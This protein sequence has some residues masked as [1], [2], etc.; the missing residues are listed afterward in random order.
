M[1]CD[2]SQDCSLAVSVQTGGGHPPCS[3][4]LIEDEWVLVNASCASHALSV[5]IG[6]AE[7]CTEQ[8]PVVI[9][10]H[11]TN[12]EFGAAALHIQRAVKH[13]P[14]GTGIV[15]DRDLVLEGCETPTLA[16]ATECHLK[17]GELACTMGGNS[18]AS[19]SAARC[20]EDPENGLGISSCPPAPPPPPMLPA[21]PP[22]P[23]SIR[24]DG[25][26]F[27]GDFRKFIEGDFNGV[28]GFTL[29]DAIFVAQAV[30]RGRS[31]LILT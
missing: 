17:D 15:Y 31:L 27:C 9:G 4:V 20:V 19:G 21:Q 29:G 8:L 2:C 7:N 23:T 16:G 6:D 12:T 11:V 3:G 1:A 14:R 22:A 28:N 24:V 13:A 30:L 5:V 18:A 25:H 10:D 26:D